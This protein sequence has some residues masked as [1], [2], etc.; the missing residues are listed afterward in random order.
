MV[1]C[2]IRIKT[3]VNVHLRMINHCYRDVKVRVLTLGPRLLGNVLGAMPIIP[4]LP[5]SSSSSGISISPYGRSQRVTDSSHVSSQ[6]SPVHSIS[7]STSLLST[8]SGPEGKH[9]QSQFTEESHKCSNDVLFTPEFNSTHDQDV[10]NL[11]SV[12][13][14]EDSLTCS[15][16][17]KPIGKLGKLTGGTETQQAVEMMGTLA[18]LV[19]VTLTLLFAL[20]LLLIVLTES[21]DVPFLRDIRETPEFQ[22][23]H[24]TYFCPLRRWLTCTLR[25][26]G[27]QLIKE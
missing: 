10:R 3:K 13:E 25:W 2:L 22:R 6:S 27:V 18:W 16:D 11:E 26:M 9:G 4:S 19:L 20:L 1:K 12:P 21:L 8:Y 7:S 14:K 24:Y 17:H 15:G 5:E 23:L